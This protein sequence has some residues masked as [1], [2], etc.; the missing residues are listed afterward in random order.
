KERRAALRSAL[1]LHAERGSLAVLDTAAFAEPSTKA[2]AKLLAGWGQPGSTLVVLSADE[3]GAALSFRN[4]DRVSV[5]E[6]SSVGVADI[7]GAGSMLC[8]DVALA[9]LAER[10]AKPARSAQPAAQAPAPKAAAKPAQAAA[11]KAATEPAQAP[12]PKAA[13][14]AAQAPAPKAA[15]KPANAPAAP[16]KPAKPR[17]RKPPAAAGES[18]GAED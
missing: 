11:P 8:S 18:A 5:L 16:A 4:I 12:A 15:T 10:A 1:S 14:K 9:A 2:A 7:V 17:T 13:A 3:R 6:Q